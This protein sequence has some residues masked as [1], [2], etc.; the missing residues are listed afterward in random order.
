MKT[1][2]WIERPT[3]KQF[4]ALASV[5]R[6]CEKRMLNGREWNDSRNVNFFV[7][8]A[9]LEKVLPGKKVECEPQTFYFEKASGECITI[10]LLHDFYHGW[11]VSCFD[12]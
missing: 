7:F 12:C 3:R 5:K 9:W 6:E 2:H 1:E 10:S 8:T 11:G 4:A